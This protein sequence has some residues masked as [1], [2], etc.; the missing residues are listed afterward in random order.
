MVSPSLFVSYVDKVCSFKKKNLHCAFSW[1]LKLFSR[2]TSAYSVC[3]LSGPCPFILHTYQHVIAFANGLLK[4]SAALQ[5]SFDPLGDTFRGARQG[6]LPLPEIWLRN[7]SAFSLAQ[8]W[9]EFSALLNP[10]NWMNWQ[11]KKQFSSRFK[12]QCAPF[13]CCGSI[14]HILNS[15][16][17]AY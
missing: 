7:P 9:N 4:C 14:R 5:I 17:S 2:S 11:W 8:F 13:C 1:E 16:K 15:S 12:M 6:S 3:R 10:V